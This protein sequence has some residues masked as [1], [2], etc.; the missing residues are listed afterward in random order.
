MIQ[1]WKSSK[2][3]I[4]MGYFKSLIKVGKIMT[5]FRALCAILAD[6]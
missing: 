3:F 2:F 4:D 1:S 5:S 6:N